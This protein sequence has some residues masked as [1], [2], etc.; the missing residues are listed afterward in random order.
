MNGVYKST[1]FLKKEWKDKR[2]KRKLKFI[3]RTNRIMMGSRKRRNL[4]NTYEDLVKLSDSIEKARE[5][6][7]PAL[8]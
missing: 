6:K 1:D 8:V 2:R 5:L 4:E 3:I 7:E